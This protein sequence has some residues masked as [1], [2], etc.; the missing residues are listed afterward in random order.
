MVTISTGDLRNLL[1]ALPQLKE[2]VPPEQRDLLEALILLGVERVEQ[3]QPQPLAVYESPEQPGDNW[4]TVHED[5]VT[6]LRE[7][8]TEAF[9]PAADAAPAGDGGGDGQ[10]NGADGGDGGGGAD[11][12]AAPAAAGPAGPPPGPVVTRHTGASIGPRIA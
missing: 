6:L 10:G 1:E 3:A 4:A 9:Q 5:R 8:L 7:R 11:G 12:P 2:S